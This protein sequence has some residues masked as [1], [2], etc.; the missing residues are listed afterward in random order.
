MRM[1]LFCSVFF[2][3]LEYLRTLSITLLDSRSST[4][5]TILGEFMKSGLLRYHIFLFLCFSLLVLPLQ[6]EEG[7]WMPTQL[8]KLSWTQLQ[9]LGLLLTPDEIYNPNAPSIEDAIVLLGGGTGSFIS[10]DGLMVTNHHVAVGAV[11]S[12]SSVTQDYLKDGFY[13]ETREKEISIP[14][15]NAS[16]VVDMTEVTNDVLAAV[17]EGM[18]PDERTK[19]IRAKSTELEKAAKGTT[20][21]TCRVVDFFYGVKYFLI[22]TEV[23]KDVRLVC[24]P[25]VSI[26]TFGGDDD[27]WMWPR[28]TGDFAFM[29]AYVSPDGKPA[30]YSKDNVPYHP[31][32][33]LPI[34]TQGF[35][36]GSFAMLLGFSGR[37]FRYRTSTEIQMQVEETLPFLVDLTKMQIDI[38]NEARKK[39]HAVS[40]KYHSRVQSISN[41]W[42]NRAGSLLGIKSADVLNIRKTEE[43]QFTQFLMTQP[44][45]QKKYG[46]VINDIEA[47]YKDLRQFNKKL[48]MLTVGMNVSDMVRIGNEF[49][50]VLKAFAKDS[51]S[52]DMK[53][54]EAR[55]AELQ[56][57]FTNIH[58]NFDV[59]VDK[60]LLS[61]MMKVAAGLPEGQKINAIQ[62]VT[63]SKTG[64]ALDRAIKEFV[65]ELYDDTKLTT[66]A[67]CEKLSGKDA[68][69]IEDDPFVQFSIALDKDLSPLT[70]S[71]AAFNARTGLLRTK[72]MEGWMK[73]KNTEIY[74]DANRT[75]RFTYG[76]VKS[77]DARD[78]VHYGYATTLTGMMQKETGAD[79]F[80]VPEKLK[81]LWKNKDF[82]QYVD[83]KLND[84]PIAFVATL[85]I[86]GG[87]SG[88][89]M[90]NGKGDL[91]GL[92]F[93]GN[94]EGMANDYFYQP[95]VNRTIGCD[96]RFV[97]FYLDKYLGAQNLLKEMILK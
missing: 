58:K 36:E 83:P 57:S 79:P 39:D 45:L 81:S 34:S 50:Q 75:L 96:A 30:A 17:T 5:T 92:A 86:T 9:Q 41:G 73:Y 51:V 94:W 16:I 46:N 85:D 89:P 21:Y 64:E 63:G 38:I 24:A 53:I 60:V 80:I 71:S 29:R 95:E 22:K 27:N 67:G 12:V 55:L 44:E 61:A 15:Y 78:A 65:D 40:I 25:P 4:I 19:A 7:E 49:R 18:T 6:S 90:I 37:T 10:N 88:S 72:F 8:N 11:Q 93:D 59:N 74:P 84:V 3:I 20:D 14:S 87:N 48:Q 47:A 54:P 56:K 23:L 76:Q 33:F 31:R 68:D 43:K 91:I 35:Q 62:R 13:A 32:K 77:Y 42:K 2:S 82:G 66:L 1:F 26:G 28:H 69:D 70:D 52:G 97:L